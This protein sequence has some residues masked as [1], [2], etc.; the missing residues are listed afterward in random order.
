MSLWYAALAGKFLLLPLFTLL[1]SLGLHILI[2]CLKSQLNKGI[3]SLESQTTDT[4][5]TSFRALEKKGYK[6][7]FFVQA[8]QKQGVLYGTWLSL[9]RAAA[10]PYISTITSRL[11]LYLKN[12]KAANLV[13]WEL[14][15]RIKNFLRVL[16]C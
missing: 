7:Y 9:F 11:Y 4:C 14:H 1:I 13:R 5:I 3:R 15:G 8:L 6:I 2:R 12:Y 16:R 10:L